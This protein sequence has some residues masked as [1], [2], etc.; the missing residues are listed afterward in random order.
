M[1]K[2]KS[3]FDKHREEIAKQH[4]T[5]IRHRPTKLV[6]SKIR[7]RPETNTTPK[8]HS[9]TCMKSKDGIDKIIDVLTEWKDNIGYDLT[10]DYLT[11][12]EKAKYLFHY[13]QLSL[14]IS[15]ILSA[16]PNKNTSS[17]KNT[18]NI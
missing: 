1:K 5:R 9:N 7:T 15:C 18:K 6:T 17:S 14:A 2:E 11:E 12:Q 3:I 10:Q 8:A 4:P 16:K 13:N